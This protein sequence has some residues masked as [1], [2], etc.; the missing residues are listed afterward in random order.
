MQTVDIAKIVAGAKELAKCTRGESDGPLDN[1]ER[2]MGFK[3]LTIGGVDYAIA[4]GGSEYY[5][6]A[7][8]DDNNH[9]YPDEKCFGDEQADEK[10]TSNGRW[11]L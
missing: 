4:L 3:Y 11:W 6:S 9:D 10:A 5:G 2:I 8:D 7:P 1:W